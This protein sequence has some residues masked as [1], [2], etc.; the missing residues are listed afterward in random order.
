MCCKKSSS[1]ALALTAKLLWMCWPSVP[2]KGGLV[3]TI[4]KRRATLVLTSSSRVLVRL[5]SGLVT[6][7]S[8]MFMVPSSAAT[9]FFS[10]P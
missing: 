3:S 5:I 9:P 6:P 10:W 7:C 4:S 8:T 1:V 2:P